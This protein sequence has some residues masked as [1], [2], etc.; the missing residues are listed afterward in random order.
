MSSIYSTYISRIYAVMT[1]YCDR[2]LYDRLSNVKD[3]FIFVNLSA[4]S[5]QN[6]EL[7]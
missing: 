3:D 5:L 6:G 1:K 7:I 4:D 2:S